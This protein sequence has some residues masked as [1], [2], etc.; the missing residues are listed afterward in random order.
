MSYGLK[1][2]LTEFPLVFDSQHN[3]F[4]HWNIAIGLFLKFIQ[5]LECL[6]NHG[7][8]SDFELKV[9]FLYFFWNFR[10]CCCSC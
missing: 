3:L 7:R 9:P 5:S 1:S 10:C 8:R 4:K 2:Y 6:E